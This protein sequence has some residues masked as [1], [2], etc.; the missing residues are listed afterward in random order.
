MKDQASYSPSIRHPSLM[1]YY[2]SG[3]ARNSSMMASRMLIIWFALSPVASF[4]FRYPA[5]RS[6]ITFDRAAILL[7]AGLVLWGWY[8]ERR[9]EKLGIS[10]TK[11]EI[12]WLL[13]TIVAISSAI[14]MS[15]NLGTATK[16]AIDSFLLPLV[17]F[18]LAHYH[19]DLKD[20]GWLLIVA[21]MFLGFV[22][23]VTGAYEMIAGTDLFAYQGSAIVREGEIRVNG[24]FASDS[25]YAGISLLVAL[26][27]LAAPKILKVKMD[28]SAQF[29]YLCSLGSALVACLLPVFRTVALALAVCWAGFELLRREGRE[30]K[31][32]RNRSKRVALLAGFALVTGLTLG[33]IFISFLSPERVTSFYN[34]YGRLATWT[35]AVKI[36]AENP[37]TGVGLNNYRDYIDKKYET[38]D[39]LEDA[40]GEIR[41]ARSPHSNI[42][43]VAAELGVVGLALYLAANAL[44]FLFGYRM[45][46]RSRSTQHRA[47]AAGFLAIAA[48]YT[49]VGLTLTSGAYS[50]LN[51]YLFFLLGLLSSEFPRQIDS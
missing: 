3:V 22:L 24:P 40:I 16:V 1:A 50:D 41:A 2:I 13:L 17:V 14:A 10:A 44:I 11:F 46:R 4:Y 30:S 38:E 21:A 8:S 25:S 7:I 29:I 37:L 39:Q 32:A 5:E 12:V 20:N 33:V 23:F 47:A 35:A 36:T 48:A 18:R 27:L 51:L 15:N 31:A 9:S 42:L 19:I 34:V 43:W 26:F 49:I 45:L 6:L 28:Q